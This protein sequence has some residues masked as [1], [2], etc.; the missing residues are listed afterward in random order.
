MIDQAR[1]ALRS[2]SID[3]ALQLGDPQL[4]LGDQCH[5]FGRLGPCDHQFR[6]HL[7]GSGALN[8]QR[9]FQRIDVIRQSVAI[10]IHATRESQIM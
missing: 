8:E 3:L 1:R 4:L 10:N 7:Q 9:I 5:V 6:G 2:L